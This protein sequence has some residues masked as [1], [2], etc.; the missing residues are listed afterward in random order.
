MTISHLSMI[1]WHR[2]TTEAE[3]VMVSHTNT[4]EAKKKC[5]HTNTDEFVA[6]SHVLVA[7]LQV[8]KNEQQIPSQH[9]PLPWQSRSV[10]QQ[11]SITLVMWPLQHFS[12]GSSPVWQASPH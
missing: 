2:A 6:C 9:V 5:T 11:S 10:S 1:C 3:N 8:V 4:T 12:K 7:A